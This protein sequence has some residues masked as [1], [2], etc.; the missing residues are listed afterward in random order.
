VAARSATTYH[1]SGTVA[2]VRR[3]GIMLCVAVPLAA[4]DLFVKATMPTQPWAYH[5]RSIAWLILTFGLL[6]GVMLIAQIPSLLV[7]PAAGVLAAGILGN[8]L[9]AAWNDME[10]PNPLLA[11]GGKA[12]IAFNL[13]DVWALTGILA[14]M[15][16]IGIW[17]IRNRALLPPTST[18]WSTRSAAVRRLFSDEKR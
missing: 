3:V 13:A 18:L 11:G 2:G 15:L 7:A 1:R 12:F 14:L 8:S 4:A 9:S 5:Q 10:V 16:T 17:L 6:G